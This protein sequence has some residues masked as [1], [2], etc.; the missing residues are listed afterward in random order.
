MLNNKNLKEIKIRTLFSASDSEYIIPIYQRNYAWTKKEIEQLIDDVN[1]Y[2]SNDNLKSKNY[3]IGSLVVY[4]RDNGLLEVIDGQQRLTTLFILLNVLKNDYK[5]DFSSS[6]LSFESRIKSTNALKKISTDDYVEEDLNFRILD[7]KKI[8]ENKLKN[9]LEVTEFSEFLLENVIILRVEVPKDTD[10]NHYFEIMNSRGEQLEKH[11]ILKSRL[12]N[13]LKNDKKAT[14]IFNQIWEACSNMEQYV[15][16]GFNTK[17]RDKLFG[18]NWNEFNIENFDNMDKNEDSKNNYQNDSEGKPTIENIINGKYQDIKNIDNL[19]S[20][21]DTP[22]RFT[23]VINF[24]NFLLHVLK[25]QFEKDIPLDDKRLLQTFSENIKSKDEVKK[26]AYNLLKVRF[27]FDNYIIK[28]DFSKEQEGEW[29]LLQLIKNDSKSKNN[30]AYY[31]NRF[32]SENEHILMLLSMFHVSTPTLIYKHWLNASLKYLFEQKEAIEV[33]E[34][35]K[36][37][38][39]LA[40][41]YMRD[42]FLNKTAESYHDIIYINKLKSQNI[43]LEWGNLNC[44]TGVENFIFNYLDYLLWEK[45]RTTY[46][47]FKFTFRTSVEHYYPQ[48]PMDNISKLDKDILNNFG[49]LCL[50]HSSENSRLS[51]FTPKAKKEFYS[52][53]RNNSI[54]QEIM[55]SYSK[56]E[57][58]EIKEHYEEMKKVLDDSL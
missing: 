8:I 25:L 43:N 34:Y 14:T 54:K 33:N 35:R 38:Q 28:R 21:K 6:N 29:S 51:N 41:V 56:W 24:P 58:K 32:N 18:S 30:T 2:V 4:R 50:I 46:S 26:F 9:L 17:Q 27:L 49:N 3:Y 55:M 44:G 45:N 23:S 1:D 19:K 57:E 10:L 40:K 47:K 42:R 12:L 7:A 48:N 36:Y 20:L 53:Q 16:Y 37:L 5:I 31:K 15:Q 13:K 52:K 39:D 11:E 22:E